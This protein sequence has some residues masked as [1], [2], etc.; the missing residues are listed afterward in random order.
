MSA[1]RTWLV[2]G[3][4]VDFERGID[5]AGAVAVEGGRIVEVVLGPATPGPDDA[6]EE[7]DGA[8]L[9][10]GMTDLRCALREPGYE[11][12]ETVSSGLR[13]AAAGGFTQVC[14]TPDTQPVVDRAAVVAEVLALAKDA[15]AA[16]L[17]PV[18]AAT[19]GL[20][21]ETL[22]P[23]GELHAS[24]CVALSTGEHPVGSAGFMRRLLE[25]ADGFGLTVLT[26]P[27]EPTMTG[28]CDEGTWSTR[29]GLPETPAAAEA[30]AVS[31][32]LLLAEL[33]GAR[34]HLQRL[35]TAAAVE[36]VR[37]AKARG[38]PVTC[39]VTPHHLHLGAS[40]LATYD[41]NLKV[42]PPLRSEADRRALR[43]ALADGTVDAVASD[44]QP[45]HLEDKSQEFERAA[46]GMSS[47]ETALSLVLALVAEGELT[48]ARA[49]ALL[50]TGPRRVLGLGGGGLTVGEAADLTAIDPGHTWIPSA[51][52]LLSRGHN[53]PWLGQALRGRAILTMVGGDVVW[54]A[55]GEEQAE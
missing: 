50:S 32:D 8:W 14:A 34:L 4:L 7:L 11:E 49:M 39:D 17:L 48:R 9:V 22:A 55:S 31:R 53:T 25:Y 24:G 5:G 51:G 26:A 18:G 28:I 15:R 3:H 42:R 54:R 13:A 45:Q 33:T 47:V 43:E 40:A 21:H 35:S 2:G 1:G 44:H 38:V 23:V 41:P 12:K 46:T 10:A 36:L 20:R 52:T 27:A 37:Q 6:V 29:L 19:L 30:I 16:R